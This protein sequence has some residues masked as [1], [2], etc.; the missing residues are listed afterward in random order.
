MN[1]EFCWQK[2]A[3]SRNLA[4]P[5]KGHFVHRAGFAISSWRPDRCARVGT[6]AGPCV[7]ATMWQRKCPVC[8]KPLSKPDPPDKPVACKCG[9]IWK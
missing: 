9:W 6:L 4:T 8:K 2:S 1:L 3:V 7:E 5:V